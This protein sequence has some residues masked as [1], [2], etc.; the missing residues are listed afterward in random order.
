MG[1]PC[2]APGNAAPRNCA[3]AASKALESAPP[4]SATTKPLVPMGT[5]ACNTASNWA[6]EKLIARDGTACARQ[7]HRSGEC[8]TVQSGLKNPNGQA[9]IVGI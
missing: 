6:A 1:N 9:Y 7:T 5:C 8:P 2:G 3:S 4:L